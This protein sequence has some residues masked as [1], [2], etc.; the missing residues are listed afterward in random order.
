MYDS[1]RY[2]AIVCILLYSMWPSAFW[3]KHR[4]EILGYQKSYVY[5]LY[6]SLFSTTILGF[7]SALQHGKRQRYILG[8]FSALESSFQSVNAGCWIYVLRFRLKR[9]G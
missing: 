6:A 7:A 3:Q 8:N 9:Y 5:L 4:N 2:Y 1:L